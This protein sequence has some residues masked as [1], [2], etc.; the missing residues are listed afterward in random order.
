MAKMTKESRAANKAYYEAYNRLGS[1]VQ[2]GVMDMGKTFD[3]AMAA[4]NAGKSM[5]EAVTEVIA[6]YRKN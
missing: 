4:H 5:D 2:V 3:E 1:G 6:K